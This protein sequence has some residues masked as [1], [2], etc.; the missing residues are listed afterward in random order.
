MFSETRYAMNG[1]LRV[2]YRAS[3]EVPDSLER[4]W[5]PEDAV[6][7][8]L[9]PTRIQLPDRDQA[10]R[11]RGVLLARRARHG[12]HQIGVREFFDMCSTLIGRTDRVDSS[13]MR[14]KW[15]FVASLKVR[16]CGAPT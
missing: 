5:P 15:C 1:D 7:W 10:A 16:A 3:R 12:V 11:T 13:E 8:L 9:R 14:A 4:I 6:G 2:A